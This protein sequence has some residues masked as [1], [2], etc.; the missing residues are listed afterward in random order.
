[1]KRCNVAKRLVVAVIRTLVEQPSL[2]T[3][4]V[5]PHR[6]AMY[7]LRSGVPFNIIA[8]WPGHE[9]TNTAHRYV[10][11]NLEMKGC[12]SRWRGCVL[13]T[14]ADRLYAKPQADGQ[15]AANPRHA[16]QVYVRHFA[17]C[18]P[19]AD[20]SASS[21]SPRGCRAASPE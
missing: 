5:P 21:A 18:A 7:L 17:S 14:G 13:E 10:E 1:M 6:T 4:R 3:E 12:T 2:K 8:L 15:G 11:A 9:S 19:A 20:A 16:A